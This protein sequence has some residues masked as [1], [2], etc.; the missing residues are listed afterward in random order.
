VLLVAVLH[1]RRPQLIAAVVHVHGPRSHNVSSF[2]CVCVSDV[3]NRLHSVL[4]HCWL[5]QPVV[6]CPVLSCPTFFFYLI[7]TI[8][9][10]LGDCPS[11]LAVADQNIVIFGPSVVCAADRTSIR[12]AIF[13]GHRRV[14]RCHSI[15]EEHGGT[16]HLIPGAAR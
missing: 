13:A 4:R 7:I 9:H 3:T 10:K 15:S 16:V 5:D 11:P 12:S 1:R 14:I 8:G 2:R 6:K